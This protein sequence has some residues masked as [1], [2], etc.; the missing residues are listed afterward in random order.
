MTAKRKSGD[1]T[2][3][4]RQTIFIEIASVALLPR[5]DGDFRILYNEI[6][7]SSTRMT[8]KR[9]SRDDTRLGNSRILEFILGNSRIP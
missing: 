5:N 4:S 9:K 3:H 6:L 1:D 7:G 2:E 8:A